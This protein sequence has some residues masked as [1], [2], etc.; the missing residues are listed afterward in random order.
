MIRRK[1]KP[2]VEVAGF[3]NKF[4]LVR[5]DVRQTSDYRWLSVP[6]TDFSEDDFEPYDDDWA[7]SPPF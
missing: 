1:N 4:V 6:C 5:D 7:N 3:H 2:P